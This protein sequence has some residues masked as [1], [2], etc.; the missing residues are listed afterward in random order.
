MAEPAEKK[1]RLLLGVQ[2]AERK[3][4]PP[5]GLV[6]RKVKDKE[7]LGSI[8]DEYNVRAYDVML[9]NW[10]TVDPLAVNWYFHHFVGCSK[11]NGKWYSFSLADKP[12]MILVPDMPP[13]IRNGPPKAVKA[14]RNGVATL[15]NKLQV[16]VVEWL[17]SGSMVEVS[18]KWLYVFSGKG[19]IDFGSDPPPPLLKK[20]APED[21]QPGTAFDPR[22]FPGVFH[23]KERPDKLE[24]E[25]YISSKEKPS[26]ALTVAVAGH[27]VK[28]EPQYKVGGYWHYLSDPT[29]LAKAT[30][31]GRDKRTTHALRNSKSVVIELGQNLRYYFLLSPVQLGPE[32]IK[33]AMAHPKGL[34]PLLKPGDDTWA[35]DPSNNTNPY[36]AHNK[37]PTSDDI[38]T[39]SLSLPVIDPYAWAE[40][41]AEVVY[42]DT[43]KQYKKW[44]GSTQNATIDQLKKQTGWTLDHLYLAQ[45]LNSIIKN[46]P[47]P[48]DILDKFKDKDKW[49]VDLGKWEKE[50]I[51]KNADINAAAHRSLVQLI[52]W[53]KGP[54]HAIIDTAILR[55]TSANGSVD[56][57]D[58]SRGIQH[59]ALCLEH[60]LALAPG[61]VYL[62]DVLMVSGTV[63]DNMLFRHL[64]KVTTTTLPQTQ[65]VALRY[66]YQGMLTLLA[67]RNFLSPPAVPLTGT[68]DEN[69]KKLEEANRKRRDELIKL[70]NTNKLLPAPV[71]PLLLPDLKGG[72]F[73]WMTA[74]TASNAMLD[75]SDKLTTYIIEPDITIPRNGRVL[76][77]LAN[78]EE[79]FNRRPK[80][81]T[82]GLN[83]GTSYS[84]KGLSLIVSSYNL[85]TAVTTARY[86]YQQGKTT[87]SRLDW[88]TVSAGSTLAIQDLLATVAGL[89]DKR[90]GTNLARI[91][92]ELTTV[93]GQQWKYG[94]GAAQITGI[95]G[96][97]F[98]GINVLAMLVSGVTTTISMGMSAKQSASVGDDTSFAFYIVGGFVGGT[99]MTTGAMVLG[100]ALMEAAAVTSATGIGA[101]VGVVLFVIGGIIAGISAIIA[102]LFTSDDY[103]IFARKCV[104]GKQ[105]DK[106]P[107]FGAEP[108]PWTH[109]LKS[110]TNT[111][112]I[113]IQKRAI[114]NLLGKFT[115]KTRLEKGDND[116]RNVEGSLAIEITPGLLM[117]DSTFE[118]A[119]HQR[120]RQ[121][122][123]KFYI[124]SREFYTGAFQGGAAVV[125]G[126]L[127]DHILVDWGPGKGITVFLEKLKYEGRNGELLNTVTLR[128]VDPPNVIRC[129][130]L[131]MKPDGDRTS[132]DYNEVTSEIFE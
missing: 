15:D 107:R 3:D 76:N 88:A 30:T 59:W 91:F 51:E 10:H 39:G 16:N 114:H 38:K 1:P 46:H 103:E 55:D 66:G 27:V 131:V 28:G 116:K 84:L 89:I 125:K 71:M 22:H 32:A 60:M 96:R 102:W 2:Y 4:D 8:A 113:Q 86:D 29:I 101:T 108:P 128:H 109:A 82:H 122:S 121:T 35:W 72:G 53:L 111:W 18:G 34:T 68:R 25:I 97:V 45:I 70:L 81:F 78:L 117:D 77:C 93:S 104:F 57:Q 112:P 105:G 5:P 85:Y 119:L 106:E 6:W 127:F 37:A 48:K 100:F 23:I 47:K 132:L 64:D 41:I 110:G 74:T 65:Q 80:W 54:G 21:A 20:D 124:R 24:Y 50:L 83:L 92:P 26:D 87:V 69:L 9:Y 67:L 40:N 62:K 58:Q 61:V 99:M 43:L 14:T 95:A 79:W 63:P 36:E 126:E 120:F 13:W 94:V 52:E 90:K 98:A 7:T 17:A 129:Q 19:G 42:E 33:Y 11:H 44:V 73:N 123:W 118:V 115:V 12:G 130:K 56:A 31:E 75:F 49:R